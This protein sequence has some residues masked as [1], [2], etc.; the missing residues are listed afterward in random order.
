MIMEINFAIS[1]VTLC[2][3]ELFHFSS[4]SI[5]YFS[6]TSSAEATRVSIANLS[7]K[8]S[9]KNN[10]LKEHSSSALIKNKIKKRH[11]FANDLFIGKS[12]P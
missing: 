10:Q 2:A 11:N 5:T 12:L 8:I 4:R 9:C 1:F 6:I 7:V 3:C